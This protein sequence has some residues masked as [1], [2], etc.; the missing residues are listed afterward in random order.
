MATSGPMRLG[1]LLVKDGL[2]SAAAV[3]EALE[4]QVVHGGRLGTNLVELGLLEE[5]ELARCLGKLH[6]LPFA[7]GEMS[8]DPRAMESLPVGFCDDHDV[9]PMRMDPTRI[10]VPIINP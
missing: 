4:S 3:D 10:S 2:V 9:V 7:S 8:P 5:K 1:E 6:G